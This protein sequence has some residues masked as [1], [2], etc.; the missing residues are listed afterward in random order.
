MSMMSLSSQA[1]AA[2]AGGGGGD[3]GGGERPARKWKDWV[4][5]RETE[6]R[7]EVPDQDGSPIDIKVRLF[8]LPGLTCKN[9]P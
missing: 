8:L 5:E 9:E 7:L 3:G 2:A 1:A 4:L 6:L